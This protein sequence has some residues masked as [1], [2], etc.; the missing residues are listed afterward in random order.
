MAQSSVVVVGTF[1][2]TMRNFE[3]TVSANIDVDIQLKTES[4]ECLVGLALYCPIRASTTQEIDGMTI[5]YSGDDWRAPV[6]ETINV[7]QATERLVLEVKSFLP[8][9]AT[10]VY[11]YENDCDPHPICAPCE[12]YTGCDINEYSICDGVSARCESKALPQC[13]VLQ[14]ASQ[15]CADTSNLDIVFVFD[16]S[17]SNEIYFDHVS[18]FAPSTAPTPFDLSHLISLQMA[19]ADGVATLPDHTRAAFI[20]FSDSANVVFTFDTYDSHA[21]EGDV[22]RD[23]AHQGGASFIDVGVQA[24]M[25]LFDQDSSS[26]RDKMLV[27]ITHGVPSAPQF[28]P[29]DL[30]TD[31][32]ARNIEVVVGGIGPEFDLSLVGCVASSEDDV[33]EIP[34]P[35]NVTPQEFFDSIVSVDE[36]VFEQCNETPYDGWYVQQV[37]WVNNRNWWQSESGSSL[38]YTGTQWQA[39]NP[40]LP[41]LSTDAASNHPTP[42]QFIATWYLAISNPPVVYDQMLVTCAEAY[43]SASPSVIPTLMPSN[44]PTVTPTKA[45]SRVVCQ[46]LNLEAQRICEPDNYLDVVILMED[47][48]A[49]TADEFYEQLDSIQE[50]IEGS[51]S[52]TRFFLQTYSSSYNRYDS[53]STDPSDIIETVVYSGG[54]S[55]LSTAVEGVIETFETDSHS[56]RKKMLLLFTHGEP[57]VFFTPCDLNDALHDIEVVAVTSGSFDSVACI[58]NEV[59]DVSARAIPVQE[60]IADINSEVSELCPTNPFDGWYQWLDD[61]FGDLQYSNGQ[62]V[63]ED[64]FSRLMS[65]PAPARG[66]EGVLTWSLYDIE[67]DNSNSQLSIPLSITGSCSQTSSPTSAPV[68]ACPQFDSELEYNY[69]NG[70]LDFNLTVST[71]VDIAQVSLVPIST[72]GDFVSFAPPFE[73]S[74]LWSLQIERCTQTIRADIE[75]V[76]NY[77]NPTPTIVDGSLFWTFYVQTQYLD[78]DGNSNAYLNSIQIPFTEFNG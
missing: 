33:I 48:D 25:D 10:I 53:F 54:A 30:K 67:R 52:T 76:A 69:A 73:P 64:E 29:C 65:E 5:T 68:L 22:I 58:A 34:Y 66:P 18:Q 11:S 17:S 1:P 26:S 49:L 2:A 7:E 19:V 50:I 21:E 28:S 31:L 47:S 13:E 72:S 55:F 36:F 62:W 20:Q 61:G 35:L 8:G 46:N 70:N 77:V 6:V 75:S 56:Q 38:T 63:I 71:Y 78:L 40:I 15:D 24:A 37:D 27:L 4:G 60:L 39:F 51:D 59:I 16:D 23:L 3:A 32:D 41:A 74:D 42:P 57:S 9:A 12:Q 43:P 14:L 45:P 44:L